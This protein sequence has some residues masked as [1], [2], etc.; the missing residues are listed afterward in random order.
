MRRRKFRKRV[1]AGH[2][3]T[4]FYT[5]ARGGIQLAIACFIFA[6]CTITHR[7]LPT[8]IDVNSVEVVTDSISPYDSFLIF[9]Q[10]ED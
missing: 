5:L 10:D 1:K 3:R 8:T 9:G 2:K 7:L 4:K 6:S